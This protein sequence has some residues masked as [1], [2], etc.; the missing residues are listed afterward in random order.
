[1]PQREYRTVFISDV[2]LGTRVSRPDLL[3]EFLKQVKVRHLYLV[4]DIVDV[5]AFRRRFF[6][7][8]EHNAVIRQILKMVKKKVKVVYIPGNHDRE[9]RDFNGMNFAGIEFKNR[10]I[11]VTRQKKRLLVIHGDEFDGVLRE[12]MMFLY[13]V[14]DYSYATAIWL[15]K[16]INHVTRWFGVDFSLS[17][18]LKTKV[19]NVVKF[20]GNFEKLIVYEARM[21]GTDGVVCGHI[22]SPDLQVFGDKI[23]GNCGCW[24]ESCSALV[25][26]LDGTLEVLHL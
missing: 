26:H 9:M 18:Y 11:H 17:K 23:Y 22:H 4:G 25:E 19:K 21:A 16:R 5:S 2:H 1:M 14:G 13:T 12:Q 10:D 7:D 8:T 15:S 20:I 24:T 6:W 3:V